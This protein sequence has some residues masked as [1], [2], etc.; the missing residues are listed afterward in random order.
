LGTYSR[1][2]LIKSVLVRTAVGDGESVTGELASGLGVGEFSGRG[3]LGV[4]RGVGLGSSGEG[5]G[6]EGDS[7][8]K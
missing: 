6:G 4:E 1:Y 7:V 5:V 8:Y 3:E 2:I